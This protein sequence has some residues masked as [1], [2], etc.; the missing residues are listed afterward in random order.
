MAA[1]SG[2]GESGDDAAGPGILEWTQ[3][4]ASGADRPLRFLRGPAMTALI[5]I[6]LLVEHLVVFRFWPDVRGYVCGT[7]FAYS[8]T[9]F[10]GLSSPR[11]GDTVCNLRVNGYRDGFSL[12]VMTFNAFASQAIG[13]CLVGLLCPDPAMPEWLATLRSGR[14]LSVLIGRVALNLGLSDVL[15]W[16]SHRLMH[17]QAW[18]APLH[19]MHHC[20]RKTSTTTN[21]IFHPVDLAIEFAGPASIVLLTH[22]FLFDANQ[23]SLV[24]TYVVFQIYYAL[25]HDEWLSLAHSKHHVACN[26]V[27]PIY[28]TFKSDPRPDQVNALLKKPDRRRND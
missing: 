1:R 17:R 5:C 2:S 26:S 14:A 22:F 21:L 23:L 8:L 19:R 3:G 11:L 15:F 18:A 7:L 13:F 24:C 25:D 20:S 6:F 27:Y 16:W 12:S 9:V 10:D 4:P 28:T